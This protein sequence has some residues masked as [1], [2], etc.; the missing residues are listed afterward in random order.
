M[1]NLYIKVYAKN[2]KRQ[3][4]TRQDKKRKEE[5]LVDISQI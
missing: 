4:K 2:E 1:Y 5:K 3:D